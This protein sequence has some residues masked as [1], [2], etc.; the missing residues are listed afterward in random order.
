M[1]LNVTLEHYHRNGSIM[2]CT[3][4]D[5][6]KAFDRVEYCKL[7][8]LLLVKKLP[9]IIIRVLLQMYLF[10]FT[11]VAWNGTL[12]ERFYK[13]N[14]VRQGAILGTILFCVYFDDLLNNIDSSGI[15]CHI[16][17]FFVGALTQSI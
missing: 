3:M 17:S 5:V 7:V 10:H 4:L 8:C 2:Y 1:I 11:Q 16:G 6:T 15:G 12:S 14:G 9:L 13:V